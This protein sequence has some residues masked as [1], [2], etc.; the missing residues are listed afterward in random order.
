LLYGSLSADP[1]PEERNKYFAL[2]QK[3]G[4]GFCVILLLSGLYY[5]GTG[6]YNMDVFTPSRRPRRRKRRVRPGVKASK[7]AQQ[8]KA[9]AAAHAP[10]VPHAPP[11]EFSTPCPGCHATL[12]LPGSAAGKRIRCPRCGAIMDAPVPAPVPV[13][14]EADDGDDYEDQPGSSFAEW[15]SRP[16]VIA[17]AAGVFG[18]LVIGVLVILLWP[19]DSSPANPGAPGAP[20]AAKP[21][22][23][24]WAPKYTAVR[25][26]PG[27][28]AHWSFD[29]GSGTTAGDDSG[30]GL[31]AKIVGAE[32][33][34]GR[35]GK[36]LYFNRD[37][38]SHVD[39]GDSPRFN[40][41]EAEAFTFAC[42]VKLEFGNS[43]GTLLGFR[44]L[45][46]DRPVLDVLVSAWHTTVE[47]RGDGSSDSFATSVRGVRQI[48]NGNSLNAWWHLALVRESGG[49]LQLFLDGIPSGEHTN[50]AAITTT[51]RAF[52]KE[53][54]WEK[55][56]PRPDTYLRGWLD[57]PC[58]FKRALTQD[59]IKTLAAKR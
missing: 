1:K 21:G 49:R 31:H 37:R 35:F 45:S 2:G 43:G 26:I 10:P 19:N 41:A 8:T 6:L 16:V 18:L 58:L 44:N 40:L 54:Y 29:E 23:D 13:G 46:D 30:N 33:T 38:K 4:A 32:W 39:L 25:Q 28:V 59:E 27:L 3:V 34:Q 52:G 51:A 5:V 42:W 24:P 53:P 14:A 48:T 9:A 11:A 15:A 56:A 7:A 47:V 55:S 36:A 57:E 50:G 17:F 20:G 12:R 22:E